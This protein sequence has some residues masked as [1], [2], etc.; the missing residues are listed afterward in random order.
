[1]SLQDIWPDEGPEIEVW[2]HIY[3]GLTLAEEELDYLP[4]NVRSFTERIAEILLFNRTKVILT[5]ADKDWAE[6][7]NE[8]LSLPWIRYA[9]DLEI[10]SE[11]IDRATKALDRYVELR[12]TVALDAIPEKAKPYIREA[13]HTY[14]FGFDAACIA[15]CRAVL[16]QLLK[17][18]LVSLSIYT[19]PQLRREKPG[20]GT[21][22]QKAKQ[23]DLIS[24][25]YER[26]V[27]VIRRGDELM[28]SHVSDE[29]ILR[30]LAADS[31]REFTI[32]AVE[33]LG[34][35]PTFE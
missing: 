31:V 14:I 26:A 16:E 21:L 30:Q 34:G 22:L 19:E 25:T 8:L 3:T 5:K 24:N 17:Y 7:D 10:A 1:M 28:H 2:N 11:G 35:P 18:C 12:P 27:Q 4:E 29:R 32:V 33:L 20:A 6:L 23:S 15:L 9:T 13:I